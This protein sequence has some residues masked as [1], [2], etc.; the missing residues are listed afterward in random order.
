MTDEALPA[1]ILWDMDGTLIDSEP[2]W[3]EAEIEL[4]TAH[5]V[6]WTHADGLTLVGNPLPSSAH[7]LKAAGI[8]LPAE[9]IIDFL[10]GAVTTRVRAHMPWITEARELLTSAR[11]L[12]VPCALVT[13]SVGGFVDEFVSQAGS[14]DVVVTGA[15]VSRGK[16]DPEAYLRAAEALGVDPA[17]CVA[18]EDSRVGVAAA[19]ASGAATIAVARH[20]ELERLPGVT[21]LGSLAGVTVADLGAMIESRTRAA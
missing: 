5:G 19:H 9:K 20:V 7:V 21:Y 14:F 17:H 15:D 18:I 11:E 8:D 13:M 3:I 10:I 2:Y 4:A 12:G 16:P 6:T 1:A